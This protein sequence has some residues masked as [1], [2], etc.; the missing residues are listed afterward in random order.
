MVNPNFDHDKWY[1]EN[2]GWEKKLKEL[3]D[4]Y[5]Y[6]SLKAQELKRQIQEHY[7]KKNVQVQG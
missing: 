5:A 3:S 6:H 2:K 7:R 1:Q 4:G